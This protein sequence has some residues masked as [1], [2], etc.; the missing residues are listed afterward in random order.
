MAAL[1]A[2]GEELRAE[3]LLTGPKEESN[4]AE[5]DLG[6]L[7]LV[8]RLISD[9]SLGALRSL[10]LA[11]FS[12][13]ILLCLFRS[14]ATEGH[15]ANALIWGVW[16]PALILLFFLAGRVWC[17]VCPL[18]TAGQIAGRGVS[19][20]LPPP[21]WLK[22]HAAWVMI[23]GLIAVI[24]SEQVFSMSEHPFPSGILLAALMGAAVLFALLFRRE[25][26]CRYACPLGNIGAIFA[27]PAV[28]NVR[29]NPSVCSTYCRTHDCH[30]G[31]DSH[32]GCPVYH[33]PLY[34]RDG[35]HCKLCL[36]CLK[37]CPHGS[38]K[39]YLRPPL[40]SLWR[41]G[42]IGD[43]LVPFAVVYFTVSLFLL[44]AQR[45]PATGSAG[46]FTA[47]LFATLLLSLAF[48]SAL[49]KI[50]SRDKGSGTEAATRSVFTLLVLAW[51][52]AMAWQ[53]EHVS[54]LASLRI[55]P[56]AGS[57]LANIF[58]T[59]GVSLLSVL[60]VGVIVAAAALAAVAF[61]GL[62]NRLRLQ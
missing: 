20:G 3:H 18:S 14:R 7:P 35:H 59:G 43:T 1:F 9:K 49:P 38:A 42:G 23:V 45:F 12:V 26:W 58:P 48:R 16:E 54:G 36:S 61:R 19:L 11:S 21:D 28:L 33:H 15:L 57:R 50:L 30:K 32:P 25:A 5:F 37:S 27:L 41:R 24:W 47:G 8:Q 44:A 40:K 56:E 51:G 13:I 39:L 22:K 55:H 46:I 53:L 60:Q 31:N 29:S 52:P 4:T 62:A 34:A 2:E 10:V 6:S 17:T